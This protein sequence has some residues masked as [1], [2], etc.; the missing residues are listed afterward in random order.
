MKFKEEDLEARRSNLLDRPGW[1]DNFEAVGVRRVSGI[2][3]AKL[4]TEKNTRN[5]VAL[6]ARIQ[7]V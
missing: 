5:S 6:F 4:I 1:T 7:V 2:A 3:R